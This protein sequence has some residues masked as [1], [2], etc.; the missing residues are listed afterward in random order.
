MKPFVLILILVITA[1]CSI[2]SQ[3]VSEQLLSSTIKIEAYK[4]TFIRGKKIKITSIGTAFFF[5]Y[6]FAKDS[7][8][9]LI[10]SKHVIENCDHGSIKITS[11]K[12]GKP[13]YKEPI[14][15]E[16]SNF[17]KRW[18]K[19]P[20]EDIAI[21]LI[22][23]ILN[24]YIKQNGTNFYLKSFAES[25]IPSEEKLNKFSA[26]ENV[27]MIGFP[28]GFSDNVNNVPIV[29]QGVT[30]TPIFLDFNG[31][32]KFLLDIPIYPGSSGSPII[33]F[34][35]GSYMEENSV[36]MGGVRLFLLGISL[37]SQ[38][39]SAIGMTLSSDSTKRVQ[40]ETSLPFGI[41]ICIKS[42]VLLDFKPIIE[43]YYLKPLQKK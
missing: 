16:L 11:G 24:N 7:V 19:H 30:A 17:Q 14:S 15:L 23:P 28:K 42:S 18:I 10:T 26:I 29:R 35:E 31:D 43:K 34:E 12:E 39:Y 41:A 25:N 4:D 21:F 20:T 3:N 27:F 40:T 2:K 32:R 6:G 22:A 8:L 1:F 38:N 36:I 33:I 13:N 9:A 37:Q 5:N